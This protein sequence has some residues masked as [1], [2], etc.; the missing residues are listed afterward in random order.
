MRSGNPASGKRTLL[1]AVLSSALLASALL[2][3]ALALPGPAASQER[4]LYLSLAE[5]AFE[6]G[7]VTVPTQVENWKESFDPTPEWGYQ[8][9]GGPPY[10]AKLAGTLYEVTGEERYAQEAIRWL[11][12]H[13]E[14]KSYFP[15]EMH[16][17]RPDYRDGIPT[18]TNFFEFPFFVEG[19]LR[20]KESP[21]LT[22][23]QREQIETS[24]AETA[25]YVFFFPEWGPH[26]RAM[27]RAYGL[28]LAAQAMPDHPDA[29]K[30]MKLSEVLVSDSWGKWEEEDAQVYHPVWL[31]SLVRYA[32]AL[33]DPS[34]YD[35]PTARYYFD[36]FTHL[37]DP[38]GMVPDFGDARWHSNWSW[39]VALLE[40]A[41]TVYDRP[42]YRWAAHRIFNAMRTDP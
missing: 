9:P 34:F 27:L 23:A 13:H 41:A 2:V 1:N 25:N 35:F 10:F 42:E 36:Y 19:Y 24:I 37:L 15:E 28:L 6:G 38:T 17:Y 39:Y 32:E 31:I 8:P 33:G 20:V 18:L 12:T 40:K 4:D 3:P 14:Y 21:S 5:R 7:L 26:N 16:G 30:W 11:S 29:G 22:P